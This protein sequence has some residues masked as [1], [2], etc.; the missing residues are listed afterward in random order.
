MRDIQSGDGVVVGG[1]FFLIT[2]AR[3]TE[4]VCSAV[5]EKALGAELDINLTPTPLYHNGVK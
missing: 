1:S 5:A 2:K 3:G 4:A